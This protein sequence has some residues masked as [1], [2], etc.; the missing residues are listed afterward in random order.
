MLTHGNLTATVVDLR[1]LEQ[2]H[3]P[4]LPAGRPGHVRAAAVPHLRADRRHAARHRQRGRADAAAAL[5]RSTPRWTT[6]S[7]SAAPISPACRRCGSRWS[8]IPASSGATCRSLRVVQLG[9]RGAAARGR[10]RG[11]AELTGQRLGGGWGMTETSPAGTNLLPTARPMPGEIGVPLP[12]IEMD[13]VALD[14]PAPRAA[15]RRGRA[16]CGSAARTSRRATGTGRRRTRAAF[17]D[18]W[19]LTGDIGRMSPD[20]VFTLVDRKK[21]M[22]ISGGFNVYPRAIEDAIHEHP[23]V[24]RGRGDRRAGPVSRPGGQGVSWSCATARAPLTPGGAAGVPRRQARP[25]RAAGR[26]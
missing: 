26:A 8:T 11:S 23:D 4:A 1:R 9:R 16:R 19:F 21:D 25:P 6:S 5:R 7:R 10:R 13:V 18:G 15:A 3:R 22:L 2:R 20:G 24:Q 12:G 17:V 14:D